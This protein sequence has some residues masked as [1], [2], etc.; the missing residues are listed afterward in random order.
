MSRKRILILFLG[1]FTTL[2]GSTYFAL[3]FAGASKGLVERALRPFL[4]TFELAD[5][6]VNLSEWKVILRKFKIPNPNHP[7]RGPLLAVE[8][9]DVDLDPNPLRTAGTVRKVALTKVGLNLSLVEGETLD[10]DQILKTAGIEQVSDEQVP[11]ITVTDSVVRLRLAP[12]EDDIVFRDVTA[13]LLP[14]ENEDELMQLSGTMISPMGQRVTLTGSCN[15]RKQEFRAIMEANDIAMAPQQAASFSS[16]VAQYL[17]RAGVA[18]LIKKVAVWLELRAPDPENPALERFGGGIG[19]DFED[20]RATPPDLP[21]PVSGARGKVFCSTSD[22]GTVKFQ[23]EKRG[24]DGDLQ[25]VGSMTNCFSRPF[26]PSYNIRLDAREVLIGPRLEHALNQPELPEPMQVWRAFAPSA[27]RLSGRLHFWNERPG[28]SPQ[29]SADLDLLGVSA[30]FE[31]FPPGPGGRRICFPYPLTNIR[32]RVQ[33]RPD[34]ITLSGLSAEAGEGRI[35]MTG[36]LIPSNGRILPAVDIEC[37]AVA[38]SP[39]LRDALEAMLEGGGAIYDEYQPQGSTDVSLQLRPKD[40]RVR[41]AASMS[42]LRASMT[43]AGFPYRVDGIRGVVTITEEGV[44]MNVHGHCRAGAVAVNGRFRF[45]SEKGLQG[46]GLHSELWINATG[47]PLDSEMKR[48]VATMSQM[49]GRAWDFFSPRGTADCEVTLWKGASDSEFDYDARLRAH[50]VSALMQAPQ[51]PM[52]DL[53]GDIFFHGTGTSLRCDVSSLRGQINNGPNTIPASILFHGTGQME[54]DKSRLNLTSIIRRIRLTDDLASALDKAEVIESKTWDL[55]APDGYVDVIGRLQ[56]G[57]DD[58]DMQQSYRIRLQDVHS[59]C[60]LLPG[61]ATDFSGD[62]AVEKGVVSF[63]NI[64]FKIDG[65]PILCTRGSAS[66]ADGVSTVEAAL[67]AESYQV[68]KR[69]A[70]IMSGPTRQIYLDSSMSGDVKI[71]DLKLTFRFPDAGP[72]FETMFSGQLVANNLQLGLA[73]PIQHINGIVT[74]KEGV[75]DEKGGHATGSVSEANA[76]IDQHQVHGV[77]CSFAFD[78]DKVEISDLRLRLHS[79]RVEGNGPNN[80]ALRHEFA[81]SGNLRMSLRWDGV[82]LTET[83]RASGMSL[84]SKYQGNLSGDI[85]VQELRGSNLL[86]IRASGNVAINN[87]NLGRVPVFST[88]YDY[89][90][91]DQRPRFSSGR[92]KFTVAERTVVLSQIKLKSSI[93]DVDGRGKV[94][95]DGYSDILLSL[96]AFGGGMDRFVRSIIEF[97]IYGYL[98]EPKTRPVWLGQRRSGRRL[99]SPLPPVNPNELQAGGIRE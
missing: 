59:S 22:N 32:G 96:R 62:V 75:I 31:G 63:Q 2:A 88:I 28:E 97:Q 60:R 69:L 18:G 12:N 17:E 39:Q 71:T 87:G 64:R 85:D 26:V 77:S 67:F 14:V 48:A 92:L 25:V 89:L 37:R 19:I 44:R 47:L 34:G 57:Y 4:Q 68:D 86:D 79:G 35:Q 36:N 94:T 54:G 51:V 5:A 3:H 23:V 53:E 66:Y 38:F 95:L 78:Q 20:L 90:K 98:R 58:K 73:I 11:A 15:V 24:M 29:V 50:G 30:K 52:E 10:L 45:G 1:F 46:S 8:R 27:G 42:P 80:L 91:P 72:S 76:I 40:G 65:S 83:M 56:K 41:F 16:E 99:L 70:R 33:V 9:V 81:G 49:A 82:S 84:A 61:K 55:L 7:S 6:D 43:Y 74:L 13:Q 93:L 21:Y